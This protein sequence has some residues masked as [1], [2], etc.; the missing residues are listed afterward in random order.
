ML[1]LRPAP[2]PDATR[3]T[4]M[5]PVAGHVCTHCQ[6]LNPQGSIVIPTPQSMRVGHHQTRQRSTPMMLPSAIDGTSWS[7]FNLA[8]AH[9]GEPAQYVSAT[10]NTTSQNAM[11]SSYGTDLSAHPERMS[12]AGWLQPMVSPSVLTGKCHED[13]PRPATPTGT[14]VQGAGKPTTA[15]KCA[16]EHRGHEPLTPYLS[17]AWEAELL[18]HGLQSRY[19]ILVQGFRVGFDLGIPLI[20]CT[21]APLNHPSIRQLNHVY[22]SI[23]SNEF[24][25]GWYIGPFT[26]MQLEASISPFQTSPLSL[27][28]KTSKP[29]KYHVVHNFSHPHNPLPATTFINLNIDSDKFPC[30]WGTFSTIFLLITRL[31]PG[32]Q[33]SVCDVAEAYRT[34]PAAPSQWPGLVICLQ[35]VDWFAV[36][37][38]N[39]FG[40]TSAGGVYGMVADAGAD[41]FWCSGIGPVAKWV[42]DHLFFR[43]L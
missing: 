43:I 20:R 14:D 2:H 37:T 18:C 22:D 6:D 38:C 24:T 35:A 36:N 7:F 13:V 16:L 5:A 39:N 12:R 27:V 9:V 3:S 10:T 28:P 31:P 1:C 8:Q 26:C 30:M 15:L 25:A 21:Y 33:A 23:I 11:A 29:G 4:A 17:G 41:I 42:D 40:L 32:S 34:I 19:P